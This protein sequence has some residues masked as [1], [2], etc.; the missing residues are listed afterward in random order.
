MVAWFSSWG[1]GFFLINP[2]KRIEVTSF[3]RITVENLLDAEMVVIE[4]GLKIAA[5]R[6]FNIVVIFTDC[7]GAKQILNERNSDPSWRTNLRSLYNLSDFNIEVIPRDWNC[8]A[9]NLALME[10]PAMIFHCFITKET[11]LDGLWM[12]LSTVVSLSCNS[13][14]I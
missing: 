4:L 7:S 13:F 5:N 3:S 9:D 11:S 12:W 2:Y 1:G 14:A 8:V 10:D 6:N